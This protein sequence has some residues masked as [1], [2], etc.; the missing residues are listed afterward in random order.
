[1]NDKTPVT[2]T[3]PLC[4]HSRQVAR[5]TASASKN[6]PH[7][8][9]CLKC[10]RNGQANTVSKEPPKRTICRHCKTSKVNRPRGLCWHCYYAPGVKELYPSTSKYARRGIG[11]FCAAAPLPVAPTTAPPGSQEKFAVLV[12]RARSGQALF[13]PN[14]A[15]WP[16]DTRPLEFLRALVSSAQEVA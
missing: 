10:A 11:N 7:W 13:H 14:D 2:V 9:R 1:M 12:K 8:P 4:S 16:D 6:R 3:C 15:R 5:Q